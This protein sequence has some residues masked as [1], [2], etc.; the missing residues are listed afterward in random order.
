MTNTH[1]LHTNV[2]PYDDTVSFEALN[3]IL[4]YH[5]VDL[6]RFFLPQLNPNSAWLHCGM[7]HLFA[8]RMSLS[9]KHEIQRKLE[10]ASTHPRISTRFPGVNSKG[11]LE[12]E[13]S[14]LLPS[15]NNVP[16]HIPRS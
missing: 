5:L 6:R 13:T 3:S 16:T 14:R 2:R 8:D 1:A 15:S 7:G 11:Y 12:A 10:R 9:T 4:S